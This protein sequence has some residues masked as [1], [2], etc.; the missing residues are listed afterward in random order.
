MLLL[1]I[2][3]AYNGF[4][5][6]NFRTLNS[7]IIPRFIHYVQFFLTKLNFYFHKRD[8][9]EQKVRTIALCVKCCKQFVFV[10]LELGCN[11]VLDRSRLPYDQQP[12]RYSVGWQGGVKHIDGKGGV[13]LWRSSRSVPAFKP[14]PSPRFQIR[15][16]QACLSSQS[17][18]VAQL[19]AL[20]SAY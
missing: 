8:P 3:Q 9:R 6:I 10:F 7:K 19:R 20:L 16:V 1:L 13:S 2:T 14:T 17:D 11:N 18:V 15:Q 5:F 4:I 12:Q